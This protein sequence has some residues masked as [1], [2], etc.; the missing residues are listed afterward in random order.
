MAD[1][2]IKVVLPPLSQDFLDYQ[3]SESEGTLEKS[4]KSGYSYGD[5]PPAFDLIPSDANL[6]RKEQSERRSFPDTY[7]LRAPTIGKVSPV[8]DQGQTGA[9]WTFATYGSLE[10]NL[11]PAQTNTFSEN[12]LYNNHGFDPIP[13]GG[14]N[15]YM[16]MAYHHRWSGPVFSED[17]PWN[18]LSPQ[19]SP[20]G[21]LPR[22]HVQEALLL[23][24]RQSYTDNDKIKSEIMDHGG[25]YVSIY[26][27]E[28]NR[29]YNST[30]HA[31]YC[32]DSNT[33]NHGITIVGWDDGYNKSNFNTTP[34][35]NGAFIAK[36]SWGTTWGADGFFYISYYDANF[37]PRSVFNNAEE[38]TNFKSVYQYDPYGCITSF[39]IEDN[40]NPITVANVFT[41][42][43]PNPLAAVGFYTVYDNTKY[44]IEIYV[45]LSERTNP[46]SGTFVISKSGTIDSAGYH[47]VPLN[48]PVPLSNGSVFSVVLAL[49]VPSPLTTSYSPI[50]LKS[51]A[52]RTSNA[53]INP[54]ES[55]V[56]HN[57]GSFWYDLYNSFAST[58]VCNNC[59]K[60]FTAPS[61]DM[62]VTKS[63]PVTEVVVGNG[64]SYNVTVTNL[65]P[66][67]AENVVL[68]DTLPAN[69][70]FVSADPQET[71]YD[72]FAR[73]ITWDLGS[74]TA[75][76][77]PS[78][79]TIN[80]EAEAIGT[81]QNRADVSSTTSD[82]NPD[83]NHA[84]F[85]VIVNAPTAD[86]EV[87]KNG[88]FSEIIVGDEF[89]YEV[90]VTNNGPNTADN[91]VLID[92]LPANVSFVSADPQ[93]AIYDPSTRTITWD[94]G[95]ITEGAPQSFF[96][97]Y[98]KAEAIGTAHNNADVSSTTS[99]PNPSNN[100]AF[101]DVNINAYADLAVTKYGSFW[102]IIVGDNFSYIVTVSNNGPNTAENAVLTDTLPI[103]VSFVSATPEETSY[104]PST[105]T[106]TWHLGN[107][108]NYD[109]KTI[110]VLVKA[111]AIGTARNN[112]D[113]SSTTLDPNPDNN[114]AFFDTAIN[115]YA[116]MAVYKWSS[117]TEAAVNSFFSYFIDVSNQG[118]NTAENVVLTDTLPTNVSFVSAFPPQTDY[119]PST[120]IITWNLG[121]MAYQEVKNF[122]IDVKANAAGLAQNYSDVVSDTQDFN[123]DN[124]HSE[125][126]VTVI[127]EPVADMGVTKLSSISQVSIGS[128][129]SYTVTVTNHGPDTAES[130]VLADQLPNNVNFVTA[131]PS[132]TSYNPSTRILTWDLGSMADKEER[133]ITV[134][135][136]AAAAGQARN[137]VD[138]S[139]TTKD[140][141][142]NNN[143]DSVDVTINEID[144][145]TLTS[146]VGGEVWARGSTQIISWNYTG[147]IKTIEIELLR[148]QVIVATI[149]SHCPVNARGGNGMYTWVVPGDFEM[150]N[151]YK[152]GIW[153][154][155]DP[156]ISYTSPNDFSIIPASTRGIKLF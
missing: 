84:T 71:I 34:L 11:L 122:S 23:P 141:N 50:E 90:I 130:V 54:G 41:A 116:D 108:V 93:E 99:D 142:P 32:N 51:T 107:I 21:L 97:V 110:E 3:K 113:V 14:G 88:P 17:D 36:N 68:T 151:D 149:A 22:K 12:N 74:I 127:P 125:A 46:T 118:P 82:P 47:T 78:S 140:P 92:T 43:S 128:D 112:A 7:D 87:T 150:G 143:H 136:M 35:A 132:E 10:S 101:V 6:V 115:A 153:S 129:F 39:H 89:S 102:E 134:T 19:P 70:S 67:T 139:S 61:A 104:E 38:V 91:V 148:G 52:A 57:A 48:F 145:L 152:I 24:E 83:N 86:M 9:C 29:Y 126:T 135:V 8:G 16:S 53:T 154:T 42:A 1:Y 49:T 37:I 131:L 94:L 25:V 5:I 121:N 100:H 64:F 69:V 79:F 30:T 65:G 137:N 44:E 144:S 72:P 31:Y 27:S 106:I 146:P 55:F 56:W 33:T 114:H 119:N 63:S 76:A 85:D 28:D 98:V 103:N 18:T 60:A 111:E 66:D 62:A 15:A 109:G 73:T 147:T 75:G 81:A 45:D 105:R 20:P 13:S 95:S 26:M 123:P 138:V 59:I 4:S 155:D 120:R 133:I 58:G 156:S 2:N 117:F 77:L 96:T 124:N 80:V 40:T